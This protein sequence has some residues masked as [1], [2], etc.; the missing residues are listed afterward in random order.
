MNRL[1]RVFTLLLLV[2][3]FGC[4][5]TDSLESI[6]PDSSSFATKTTKERV[7]TADRAS[8]TITV[9]D[10]ATNSIID[11]YDMPDNGEPMYAVHIPQAKAVYVGD[12][13]NNRVVAFDEDD[14]SVKGVVPAGNGVFHM[15]AS[16]NGTQLWVN[17]DVDNTTTVINPISMKVKGTAETPADL[18][19]D[20]GKPHDVFFDPQKNFAYV[21]VLGVAGS[22]D[23]I[24]KYKANTRQEVA[25][26]AV[27]KDPHIFA[28]DVNDFLYVPCQGAN[29]VYV[30]D[31]NSMEI[32]DILP[33]PG[34]HGIFMPG[35]G[36]HVYVSNISGAALGTFE[37]AGNTQVGAPVP[38]PFVIPHNLAVNAAEDRLYVTHSGATN[39]Q[40]SIYSVNP[41]PSFITNL[42]VGTNPFG[43]V[44]YQY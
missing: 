35:S 34:A 29:A 18:V 24:I 40:L 28:D 17:N 13:A 36:S 32:E 14:F 43:L 39:D 41:T 20:G 4:S 1:F 12:R 8:G 31:R 23:Y 44:Y 3:L 19:A 21:S 38:T 22:H 7:V 33:L 37:T 9:I 15:W 6:A 42:T 10:A 30:I 25:R 16:P 27:G 11:T 2:G 26:V 5:E